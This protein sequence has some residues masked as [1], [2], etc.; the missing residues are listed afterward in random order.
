MAAAAPDPAYTAVFVPV[1]REF[2]LLATDCTVLVSLESLDVELLELLEST[3]LLRLLELL[4]VLELLE[5]LLEAA[6]GLAMFVAAAE[7]PLVSC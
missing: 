4:E 5:S 2:H 7:V 3:E 1:E 6:S